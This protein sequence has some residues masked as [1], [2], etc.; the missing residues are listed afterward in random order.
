MDTTGV[1][2]GAVGLLAL[3]DKFDALYTLFT[4]FRQYRNEVSTFTTFLKVKRTAFRHECR[5]LSSQLERN[6]KNQQPGLYQGQVVTLGDLLEPSYDS[7]DS[8]LTQIEQSLEKISKDA[9]AFADLPIEVSCLHLSRV[10]K[11]RFFKRSPCQY[12]F[13]I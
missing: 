11:H 9:E 10:T 4:N 13:H 8:I 6:G 7:C 12:S 1:V 3:A 2:L 5:L